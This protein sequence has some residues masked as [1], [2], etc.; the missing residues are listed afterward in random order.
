MVQVDLKASEQEQWEQWESK[1]RK[2]R[3]ERRKRWKEDGELGM[4][5]TSKM[6]KDKGGSCVSVHAPP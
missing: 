3:L 6:P 1:I 2:S 4:A 5:L